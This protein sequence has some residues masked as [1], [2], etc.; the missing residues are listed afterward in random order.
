MK[1]ILLLLLVCTVVAGCKPS[2][3]QPSTSSQENNKEN[4][5]WSLYEKGEGKRGV[6]PIK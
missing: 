1:R 6:E 3:P 4:N 2:V 5:S